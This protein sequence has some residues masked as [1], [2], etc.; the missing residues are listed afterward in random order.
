[1]GPDRA[2]PP[3]V[4]VDLGLDPAAPVTLRALRPRGKV[5]EGF[6]I[7]YGGQLMAH[8]SHTRKPTLD[9][10]SVAAMLTA[11]QA[12][13][14]D[15]FAVASEGGLRHMDFGQRRLLIRR[16]SYSYLAVVVKGRTPGGL[17]K[18]M[19]ETLAQI[20][21]TYKTVMVD[22]SG[23]LDEMAGAS[24]ML[25]AGVLVGRR[26][27]ALRRLGQGCVRG[28]GRLKRGCLGLLR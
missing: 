2:P 21:E 12:F 10:D 8:F 9:R 17:P 20:E 6:L 27:K 4:P 23:S 13:I 15:T 19:E 11:V 3:S 25:A 16:G 24:V 7:N 22:W 14:R 5:E 18:R 28:L 26:R 1:M